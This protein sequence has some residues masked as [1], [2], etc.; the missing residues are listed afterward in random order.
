MRRS[1]ALRRLSRDHH[2]TLVEAQR[3]RRATPQ[4][5][6]AACERF[7]GFWDRDGM[8]HFRVEEEILLPAYAAWGDPYAPLIARTLCDH[9]AIRADADGLKSG[10][11]CSAADL[12]ALGERLAAHVRMEE[13][14][15]FE[16]IE[17]VVPPAELEALAEAVE[18]AEHG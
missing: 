9:A 4:T 18:R 3:L 11:G 6:S 14:E 16:L 10:R 5:S 7:L 15:L 1:L 12:V 2:A 17:R 13:R 8:R